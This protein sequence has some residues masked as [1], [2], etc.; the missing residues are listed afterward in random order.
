MLGIVLVNYNTSALSVRCLRS[1]LSSRDTGPLRIEII[2]NSTDAGQRD[3]LRN[4]LPDIRDVVIHLST[5]ETNVGFAAGCNSGIAALLADPVVDRILLINNDAELRPGGLEALLDYATSHPDADMFGASMHC[6]DDPSRIDSLG[7]AMYASGLASNRKQATDRLLGPTGGLALYSR[8]LLETVR[9]HHGSIFDERF[10]C[11]AEDTDLAL[12][13]LLLGF[14]PAFLDRCVALHEG[15]ASSGGG[16]SDFVLYHGIR[17]SIW[18]LLKTFPAALLWPLAPVI[19]TL[20][21][22]IVVRHTLAGRGRVVWRLYRD[23]LRGAPEMWRSRRVIQR[24]RAIRARALWRHVTPR[25]YDRDYLRNAWHDLWHP[26]ANAADAAG[27]GTR[28]E[29]KP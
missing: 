23:A 17:N 3:I 9:D 28:S 27:R 1:I 20:H 2:D 5:M 12:R 7:I 13:A 14:K 24:Q 6:M 25:F 11:Y 18:T 21:A 29:R 16:F 8:K 19:M 26:H 4:A 10:F 22:G 15:Q